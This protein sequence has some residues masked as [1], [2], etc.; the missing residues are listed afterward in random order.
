MGLPPQLVRIASCESRHNPL[1]KSPTD[2]WG[3]FQIHGRWID[4]WGLPPEIARTRDQLP[5][6]AANARTAK[7]IYDIQ[8]LNA[9]VCWGIIK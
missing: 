2:N 5:D 9:W 7:F 4:D 1:A 6:P 3:L 8:G